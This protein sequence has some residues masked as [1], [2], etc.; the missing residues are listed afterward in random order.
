MRGETVYDVVRGDQITVGITHEIS[1]GRDKS[2]VRYEQTTQQQQN[3][4]TEDAR[5]RAIAS[6]ETG[7]MQAVAATVE[8]LRSYK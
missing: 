8:Q 6:A 1:V 3:E 4:S 7:V 5:A 2:W